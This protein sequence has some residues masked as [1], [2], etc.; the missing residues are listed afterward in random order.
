MTYTSTSAHD[1]FT[2]KEKLTYT[3][4]GLVVLGGSFFIGRSV[5]RRARATSEEKKT[6][7]DGNAAYYAQKLKMAFENDNYFG[8]GTDEESIRETVRKI[9]SKEEFKKV[10]NSY[11]KLYAKSL[12]ADL[13]DELATSEY[14]EVLAIIAG[15]PDSISGNYKPVVSPVQYRSWAKRLKAAFDTTYWFMPGTDEAAIK[16]V[17]MEIPTQADFQRV[18]EAYKIE[19]GNDLTSDLRSEL[20]FWEY[21]TMMD[22]INKKPKV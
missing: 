15:K 3:V 7:D 12:M 9:P 13:K 20:E 8:W 11:Q 16:A 5:V 2:L 19:Y 22:I 14:N 17:F 1:D 10:I 4:V 18:A 6:Y 21:S